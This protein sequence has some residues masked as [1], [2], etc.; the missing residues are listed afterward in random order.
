MVDIFDEVEDDLRAER[1]ARLLKRYAWLIVAVAVAAV[2]AAIGW[3]L[4]ARWQ[5]GQDLAAAQRY[6]AAQVAADA[7]AGGTGD[8]ATRSAAIAALDQQAAAGPE[9]YR[10]LMWLRAAALKADAGDVPGAVALWDRVAADPGADRLLRDLASLM[11]AQRQ[12]DHGDPGQLAARLGPLAAAGNPWSALAREQLALL[13]LRQ[14]KAAEA[15]AALH[16]LSIDLAA[17]N[18]VRQRAAAIL[19]GPGGGPG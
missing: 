15:K 2:G 11:A 3:Q 4:W 8:A 19:A 9:G 13:D 10:T 1:V 12:L 14:G 5:A 18:G 7:A 17:P 16:A 6:A